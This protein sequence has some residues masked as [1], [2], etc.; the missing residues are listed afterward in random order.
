MSLGKPS[1]V[2]IVGALAIVA[3]GVSA[4][5]SDDLDTTSVTRSGKSGP[6]TVHYGPGARTPTLA[7]TGFDASL[8][9]SNSN[10]LRYDCTRGS[11]N[12]TGNVYDRHYKKTTRVARHQDLWL[13]S[14]T[15][16]DGINR[17]LVGYDVRVAAHGGYCVTALHRLPQPRLSQPHSTSAHSPSAPPT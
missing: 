12:W 11:L 14:I 15:Y 6:G 3:L 16:D 7:A 2:A 4:C 8:R 1:A 13:V 10:Y 17:D 5:A 9:G